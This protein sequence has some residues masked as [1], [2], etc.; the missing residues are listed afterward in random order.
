[1]GV[2]YSVYV[3]PYIQ[4]HN[5]ERETVEKYYGCPNQKKCSKAGAAASGKFCGQCGTA[6]TLL[7]KPAKERIDFNLWDECDDRLS[8]AFS[9]Y[10]PHG[11][12][13]YQFFVPNVGKIG[14][15]FSAYDSSLVELYAEKIMEDTKA[16]ETKFS[17][18]LET[19][20]KKFGKSSVVVRWGVIAYA[21]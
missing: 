18:D 5:P 9:E 1:M 20:R 10:P 13:D 12:D 4:V 3:G 19:L 21:S 2:S 14:T 16:L 17:A 7:K 8:Q 15:H 11:K 6:I